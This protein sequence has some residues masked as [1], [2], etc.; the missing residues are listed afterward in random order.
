M[1]SDGRTDA[2]TGIGKAMEDIDHG[3]NSPA[4][5]EECEGKEMEATEGDTDENDAQT[6]D[7]GEFLMLEENGSGPGAAGDVLDIVNG[8]HTGGTVQEE[9]A[10]FN[11][12]CKT[13][14]VDTDCEKLEVSE[15]TFVSSYLLHQSTLSLKEEDTDRELSDRTAQSVE[16]WEQ[17]TYDS[18]TEDD[19]A[20]IYRKRTYSDLSTIRAASI[21]L[22]ASSLSLVHS[23]SFV[24]DTEAI[25]PELD[26]D[27][28]YLQSYDSLSSDIEFMEPN[29]IGLEDFSLEPMDSL[30]SNNSQRL[31]EIG[32]ASTVFHALNFSIAGADWHMASLP[33]RCLEM[34]AVNVASL[35]LGTVGI[36]VIPIT[37]PGTIDITPF[38]DSI[39]MVPFDPSD[40]ET[41][42]TD[43][44]SLPAMSAD[45]V[46]VDSITPEGVRE[47][48]HPLEDRLYALGEA[49]TALDKKLEGFSPRIQ[50]AETLLSEVESSF[51]QHA[52]HISH[53]VKE[54]NALAERVLLLEE[55]L[56]REKRGEEE[57]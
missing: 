51:S 46:N 43:S 30:V 23:N 25:E 18:S 45:Y 16:S 27:G 38:T 49:L 22:D 15:A 31:S 26:V 4:L 33:V 44:V 37:S 39:G 32:A 1:E 24:L 5:Q 12:A 28:K 34:G 48:W 11:E 41:W 56:S 29:D 13:F 40:W 8:D 9:A 6:A 21:D 20:K 42:S 57:T 52:M 54:N 53:I 7:H 10:G 47:R 2:D 55:R 14:L 36:S 19:G 35:T 50:E 3:S 17:M